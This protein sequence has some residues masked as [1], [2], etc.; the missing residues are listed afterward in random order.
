MDVVIKYTN[1]LGETTERHIIPIRIYFGSTQY[2]QEA[3]WL[4]EAFD[5]DRDVARTFA[6][7]GVLGWESKPKELVGCAKQ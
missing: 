4:L 5:L 6:L 7:K 3:Q 2:H 1:Y